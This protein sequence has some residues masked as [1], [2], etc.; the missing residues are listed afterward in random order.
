VL[1]GLNII[2]GLSFN[3]Y[4]RRFNLVEHERRGFGLAGVALELITAPVYVAAAAA[5]LAGRPL[6]YVVTAKGSA[7]TG[8]TWRAFRP[9]L[10]WAAIA[11]TSMGL[12]ITFGHSYPSL[13][14]W[15]AITVLI[16]LSPLAHIGL[17]RIAKRFSESL[18]RSI[19]A[20]D[21][22]AQRRIGVVLV[23]RGW[24]SLGQLEELLD[25][26]AMDDGPRLRIG[27][28]AV[29]RGYVTDDQLTEAL[30]ESA[31]RNAASSRVL[32]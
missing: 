25:A 5:Q 9:H 30:Q 28:M 24:L 6:V 17:L 26:Q 3:Q 13:Y 21:V 16:T 4:L 15:A 2:V 18:A 1:F 32:V 14:I 23:R 29:A 31:G 11:I 12:G 10:V 7:A 19:V 20:A 8:D 22:P 27:E